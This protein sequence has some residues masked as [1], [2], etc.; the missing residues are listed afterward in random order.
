MVARWPTKI[1]A[2]ERTD[3]LVQYADIM[4]TLIT[5]AGGNPKRHRYDGVEFTRVLLKNAPEHRKYVYGV[6]N[7][8]PEG[9][10]YPIRT[11]S[12]GTYRYIENLRHE[13]LYIEKHLMGSRGSGE[14]NNPYWATWVWSSM[15]KPAVYRLVRRYMHRPAQQFYHTAVDP[16]ELNNLAGSPDLTNRQKQFQSALHRWMKSQND[17]GAELDTQ[18]AVQA[19]RQGKHLYRAD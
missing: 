12:D 14:L 3:A 13:E 17:P 4:P 5:L 6:H 16:Y 8:I 9:P 18:E 11:I 15:E 10:S 19:A 7:N 1:V 2:G